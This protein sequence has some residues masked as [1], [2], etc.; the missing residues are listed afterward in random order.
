MLESFNSWIASSLEEEKC[1]GE[2]SRTQQVSNLKQ[3]IFQ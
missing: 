1:N 3:V 2:E